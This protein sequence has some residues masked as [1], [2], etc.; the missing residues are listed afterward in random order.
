[1]SELKNRL[2]QAG[3]TQAWLIGQLH[4]KGISTNPQQLSEML[5]GYHNGTPKAN[6]IRDAASEILDEV[7]HE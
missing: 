5:N 6:Q 2:K 3:K 7:E 1:M 4:E